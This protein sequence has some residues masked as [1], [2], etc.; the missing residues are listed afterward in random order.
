MS[1]SCVVIVGQ[2]VEVLVSS[3]CTVGGSLDPID[4]SRG[5]SLTFGQVAARV[6]I[7]EVRVRGPDEQFR[8]ENQSDLHADVVVRDRPKL[9]VRSPVAGEPKDFWIAIDHDLPRCS[10]RIF[11]TSQVPSSA[12]NVAIA[13]LSGFCPSSHCL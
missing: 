10:T 3:V 12:T 11:R 4:K 8:N 9:V 13:C 7:D 1:M 5:L 6:A 2:V